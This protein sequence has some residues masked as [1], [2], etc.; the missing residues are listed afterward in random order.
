MDLLECTSPGLSPI[1]KF[2]LREHQTSQMEKKGKALGSG[3]GEPGQHGWGA[4]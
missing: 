3:K 1:G 4:S 2:Q